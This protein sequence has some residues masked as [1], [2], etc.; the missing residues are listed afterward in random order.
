MNDNIS[1]S[2]TRSEVEA[3]IHQMAP[4]KSPGQMDMEHAFI[5]TIVGLLVKRFAE[6]L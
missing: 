1:K 6:Q 5:K 3:A 2:F 4:L